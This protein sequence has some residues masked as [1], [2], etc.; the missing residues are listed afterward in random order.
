MASSGMLRSVALVRT[1]GSEEPITSF[2]RVTRISELGTTLA[3]TS[4]VPSSLILV[5]L[6]KEE[7]S[8]F[9]TSV[10]TRA[11]QRNIPKDGILHRHRRGNL[12]SYMFNS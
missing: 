10:L 3:A 8:S 7:L 6:M 11:R 9:E 12:K 5:T 4:V 2:I 1:D